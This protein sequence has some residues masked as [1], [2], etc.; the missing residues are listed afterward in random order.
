MLE[1][2][3]IFYVSNLRAASIV[4]RTESNTHPRGKYMD[5]LARVLV[6]ALVGSSASHLRD[7]AKNLLRAGELQRSLAT[8]SGPAAPTFLHSLAPHGVISAPAVPASPGSLLERQD[9][10]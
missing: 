9:L 6:L 1:A 4:G 3:H 2:E 8:H 10:E 5:F 7:S